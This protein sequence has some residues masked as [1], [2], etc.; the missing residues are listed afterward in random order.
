M[1]RRSGQAVGFSLVCG[2]EPSTLRR[3]RQDWF[4]GRCATIHILLC[5]LR[6]PAV[7]CALPH[8][9]LPF[10]RCALTHHSA[11]HTL[12]HLPTPSHTLPTHSTSSL[13]HSQAIGRAWRMGQQ[14]RV[15]VKRFYVKVGGYE[16]EG[17]VGPT[18]I[19]PLSH[20]LHSHLLLSRSL[21]LSTPRGPLRNAL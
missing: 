4:T 14:R 20:T 12:S 11:L 15:V 18:L 6:L 8:P 5:W 17:L 1:Y 7:L 2:R 9:L 21:T 16:G 19:S 3:S 13:N 10:S